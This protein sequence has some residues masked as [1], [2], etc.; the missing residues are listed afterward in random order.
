MTNEAVILDTA[1]RY[2]TEDSDRDE[3]LSFLELLK[4]EPAEAADQRRDRGDQRHRR[5]RGAP[6]GRARPARARSARA[7]TR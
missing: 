6:R 2:T 1:G 7:S 5:V 4:Q 3:W